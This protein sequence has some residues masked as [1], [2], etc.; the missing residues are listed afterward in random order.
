[1]IV[2]CYSVPLLDLHMFG[3]LGLA[4]SNMQNQGDI[5]WA[6]GLHVHVASSAQRPTCNCGQ[7]KIS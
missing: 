1:M 6:D 5:W 2:T 4:C 7:I 3:G